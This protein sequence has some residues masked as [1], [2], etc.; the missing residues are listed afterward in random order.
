MSTKY[1]LKY[2][3]SDMETV[4]ARVQPELTM[5]SKTWHRK[6]IGEERFILE[7]N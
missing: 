7:N 2:R 5:V 4:G 3:D 1:L 6:S